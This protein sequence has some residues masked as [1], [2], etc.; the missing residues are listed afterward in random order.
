MCS[1][2]K[3]K[4]EIY[5]GY[6]TEKAIDERISQIDEENVDAI[7]L[8]EKAA[9]IGKLKDTIKQILEEKNIDIDE[10]A[11]KTC[12]NRIHLIPLDK[13]P[14]VYINI[15]DDDWYFTIKYE[16]RSSENATMKLANSDEGI[17][18]KQNLINH[19]RFILNASNHTTECQNMLQQIDKW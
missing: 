8:K 12:L 13:S 19:M 3:E 5:L 16:K 14:S 10:E 2:G 4:V 11:Y 7:A 15:F 18:Q 17:K 9:L 6:P 1:G